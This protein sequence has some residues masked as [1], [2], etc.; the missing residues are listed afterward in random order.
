MK[1]KSSIFSGARERRSFVPSRER[2]GERR[3]YTREAYTLGR[4]N[5]TGV[6]P[7]F[8]FPLSLSAIFL[9]ASF[10]AVAVA[11]AQ[12]LPPS[13]CMHRVLLYVPPPRLFSR[14]EELR[15]RE[16]E[17]E[18]FSR[19]E[20]YNDNCAYAPREIA[21]VAHCTDDAKIQ[22]EVRSVPVCVRV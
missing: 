5:E 10:A 3:V 15:E 19:G 1:F 6:R 8:A 9:V 7:S 4:S 16:R 18:R 22:R 14:R 12:Q 21:P 2:E 11:A 13:R 17:K 20:R